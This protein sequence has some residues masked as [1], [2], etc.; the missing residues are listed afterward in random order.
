MNLNEQIE[1]MM[2]ASNPDKYLTYDAYVR[3]LV[4]RGIMPITPK[5][6]EMLVDIC[7]TRRLQYISTVDQWRE[8]V[9]TAFYKGEK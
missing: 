6:W 7:G 5:E 2:E 3:D 4:E 1:G 9:M 8:N